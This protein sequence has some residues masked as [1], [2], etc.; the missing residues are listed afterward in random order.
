MNIETAQEII[1]TFGKEKVIDIIN[2]CPN[3][4]DIYRESVGD[5]TIKEIPIDMLKTALIIAKQH[6]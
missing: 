1:N 4:C 2:N 6:K 5:T 3:D